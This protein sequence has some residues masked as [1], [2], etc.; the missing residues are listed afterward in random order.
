MIKRIS[1]LAAFALILTGCPNS[2]ELPERVSPH[3]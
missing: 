2:F 3:H 1:Y